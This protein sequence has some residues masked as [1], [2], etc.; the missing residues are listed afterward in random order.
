[1]I[2][3]L[4]YT[5]QFGKHNIEFTGVSEYNDF[6]NNNFGA[7][8]QQYLI[9]QIQDND[10]GSSINP[11]FNMIGSY[12]EEY[13]LESF[14]ARLNYNYDNK[15]Y[16]TASIRRD[17]SSKFGVNNLWG[18][19]PSFDVAWRLKQENFL[20]NISWITDLKLRAGYGV[21]GNSDAISPYGTL[22]LYGAAGRYYDAVNKVY[23]Q[24]YSP[25]QN[26]NPDLKWEE[27]H[28]KNLGLDFSFFDDHLSGTFDIFRDKTVNL[29]FDYTVPTPPFFINTI[30]A[31]VGALSNNGEEFSLSADIINAKK[32]TWSAD[33]QLT[34][35]R[36][37][38][39]NLSGTYSGYNVSTNDIPA[40]MYLAA[41]WM[42]IQL[43]F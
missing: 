26:A 2:Y 3:I 30:L 27:R 42:I 10:L 5:K 21:T 31:N 32:F 33:G 24:S 39:D 4:N 14:L 12:K 13:V 7:G 8:G 35:I 37:K 19:F 6:I 29:L 18:N 34:F 11:L 23:P 25:L 40:G 9:P 15:Y 16:L 38:I 28:G 41:D 22:L 20:K 36:T 17:G 43:H 1:M